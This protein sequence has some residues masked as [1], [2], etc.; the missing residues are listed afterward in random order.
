MHHKKI[1][2]E[3]IQKIA[4]ELQLTFDELFDNHP[5]API[6]HYT[7]INGLIGM[8]HHQ[9]LWLSS[10]K[11]LNDSDEGLIFI[12]EKREILKKINDSSN[13]EDKVKEQLDFWSNSDPNQKNAFVLS[14][15][16]N[17]LDTIKHWTRY[18]NNG[19]GYALGFSPSHIIEYFKGRIDQKYKDDCKIGM[20]IILAP[21]I[22][23]ES[24][25]E[26]IINRMMSAFEDDLKKS[27]P[28]NMITASAL[29][30]FFDDLQLLCKNDQFIDENEYRLAIRLVNRRI[31]DTN[32]SHLQELATQKERQKLIDMVP[33]ID[34]GLPKPIL[35]LDKTWWCDDNLR[36]TMI[37]SIMTGPNID[38]DM[39]KTLS[40]SFD[41]INLYLPTIE[42]SKCKLFSLK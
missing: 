40:G 17:E 29:G 41:N 10:T 33:H 21:C 1:A 22:Y 20:R 38:Y 11:V 34:S 25:L 18:G 42:K 6:Y 7:D 9:Y 2:D 30:S 35:K 31:A 13:L 16:N 12:N 37:T 4:W 3:I 15:V 36:T 23:K 28:Y 39:F 32:D 8:I 27:N 26:K 14:F 24:D 5:H 19:K